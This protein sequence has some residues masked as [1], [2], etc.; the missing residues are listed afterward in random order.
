MAQELEQTPLDYGKLAPEVSLISS[1]GQKV[2]RSQFRN[3]SALVLI[4]FQPTPEAT[5]LLQAIMHDAAEYAELNAQVIGI[6][7]ASQDEL[8]QFAKSHALSLTLLADQQGV[9]WKA[10]AGTESPGYGVFVLDLYGGVD[11][12]KVVESV[13]DLPDA[14][15]I[16]TWARA[17]QYRC[18]I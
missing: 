4:F 13:S 12:Q 9:A 11:S 3:K 16:L 17:A 10:Y 15:T 2:T 1:S 5:D 8:A 7:R 14:A 6:G 18:N